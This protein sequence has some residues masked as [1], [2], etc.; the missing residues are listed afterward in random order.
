MAL[1][2]GIPVW[3]AGSEMLEF[4]ANEAVAPVMIHGASDLD[5]RFN[6]VFSNANEPPPPTQLAAFLSAPAPRPPPPPAEYVRRSGDAHLRGRRSGNARP[7]SPARQSASR[8][9]WKAAGQQTFGTT[10]DLAGRVLDPKNSLRTSAA[11]QLVSRSLPARQCCQ[12][13]QRCIAAGRCQATNE[14]APYPPAQ[15]S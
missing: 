13:W 9:A 7:S 6:E 11:A 4:G 15:R 14:P 5:S 1:A 2:P 3:A 12:S 8:P 10:T